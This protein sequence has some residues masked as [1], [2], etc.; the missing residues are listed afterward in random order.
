MDQLG[1]SDGVWVV[2]ETGFIKK[3]A[4]SAGV[5]RQYTG[6]TGKIDNCQ[7]GVFVA[8]ASSRGRALVDRE[9]YLPR[10]WTDDPD[11]CHDAGIPDDVGFATKPQ[12]A[13]DMLSRA[14]SAGVLTGG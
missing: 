2:D 13:I 10:V 12:L 6:T 14:Y 3:G 4:R 5:A 7:V 8:Y 1:A 11:R 9:L